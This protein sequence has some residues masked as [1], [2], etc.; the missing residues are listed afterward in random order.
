M[1]A[2]LQVRLTADDLD[3]ITYALGKA[4]DDS[5]SQ[6]HKDKFGQLASWLRFRRVKAYG[7]DALIRINDALAIPLDS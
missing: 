5:L 3:L 4:R 1:A 2:K 7:D 6:L